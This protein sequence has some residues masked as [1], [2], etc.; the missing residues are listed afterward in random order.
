MPVSTVCR[1][2]VSPKNNDSVLFRN[3]EQ[4]KA[5]GM[6]YNRPV[7]DV[8]DF[9]PSQ[10]CRQ[11]FQSP[12]QILEGK[13]RG[14]Q[15]V[16]F[17]SCKG[18]CFAGNAL[19][20]CSTCYKNMVRFKLISSSFHLLPLS[21]SANKSQNRFFRVWLFSSLVPFHVHSSLLLKFFTGVCGHLLLQEL[22][23][24][25]SFQPVNRPIAGMLVQ[26]RG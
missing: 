19:A 11:P 10:S 15:C 1:V 24:L 20:L 22:G 14:A 5:M 13:V 3:R 4:G 23:L 18:P 26:P 25:L 17:L 9:Q 12:V 16:R 21:I 2:R 6:P 7:W 8:R